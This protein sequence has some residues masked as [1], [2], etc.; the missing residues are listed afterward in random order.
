MRLL[1]TLNFLE[2]EET[3]LPLSKVNC[4][5]DDL[6]SRV[7]DFL[8]VICILNKRHATPRKHSKKSLI[9]LDDISLLSLSKWEKW[10]CARWN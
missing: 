1:S 7:Y 10:L 6:N 3:F 2:A 8:S 4:V 9:S 5:T